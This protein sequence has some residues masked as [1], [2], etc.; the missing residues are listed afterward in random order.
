M[1]V[2]TKCTRSLIP[3]AGFIHYCCSYHVVVNSSVNTAGFSVSCIIVELKTA[4]V[5]QEESFVNNYS[6]CRVLGFLRSYRPC[7]I[8]DLRAV[9]ALQKEPFVNNYSKN[10][11]LSSL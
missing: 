8:V 10:R 7:V 2:N 6:K 1:S 4:L 5:L 3:C 9:I 11:V